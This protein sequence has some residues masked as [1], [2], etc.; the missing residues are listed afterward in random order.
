MLDSTGVCICNIELN[1]MK[2]TDDLPRGYQRRQN[3]YFVICWYC[4]PGFQSFLY[5]K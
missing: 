2:N 1:G 3:I 4:E 5:N